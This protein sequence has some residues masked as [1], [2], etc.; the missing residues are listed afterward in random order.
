MEAAEAQAAAQTITPDEFSKLNWDDRCDVGIYL[1]LT[2]DERDVI[3]A[4]VRD[5][6][7]HVTEKWRVDAAVGRKQRNIADKVWDFQVNGDDV[8]W[9]AAGLS[10]LSGQMY[11]DIEKYGALSSFAPKILRAEFVAAVGCKVQE[12][13]D[14]IAWRREE[15]IAGRATMHDTL[16]TLDH[17]A[18]S[19]DEDLVL[20]HKWLL[21]SPHQLWS[22]VQEIEGWA[23]DYLRDALLSMA[24]GHGTKTEEC[25]CM[26]TAIERKFDELM[27]KWE[28]AAT[29]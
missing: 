22:M 12:R 17:D 9:L 27:E 19:E 8:R 24:L 5:E 6:N 15:V 2:K 29:P 1:L 16:E 4:K 10:S 23:Q 13:K 20:V 11:D 21:I 18:T 14:D 7:W 28:E 25:S 3:E 26:A